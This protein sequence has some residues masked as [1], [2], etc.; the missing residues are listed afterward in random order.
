M[1][2]IK[3]EQWATKETAMVSGESD[4][5]EPWRRTGISGVLCWGHVSNT[6][7]RASTQPVGKF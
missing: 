5:Y 4:K 1:V 3:G 7:S 2:F 6:Y